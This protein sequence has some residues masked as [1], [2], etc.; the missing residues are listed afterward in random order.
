[1]NGNFL[2]QLISEWYEYQNYYVKRNEPVGKRKKGGY[3]G[4]LDVVAFNPVKNHLVHIETST[5]ALSWA[6]RELRFKKK[7]DVGKKYI[8]TLFEGYQIPD[9]IEQIAVLVFASKKN[10]QKI[11]G[12]PIKLASEFLDEIITSLKATRIAEGF[13]PEKFPILRTLH[14]VTEYRK[15]LFNPL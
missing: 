12:C 3:D 13:V 7:F 4:E 11:G 8:P 9:K 10:Y 6:K 5:D 14:F 1:M 15:E 2:E